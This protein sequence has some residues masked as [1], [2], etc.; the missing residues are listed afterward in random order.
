M[1]QS[2]IE[3]LQAN[4]VLVGLLVGAVTPLLTSLVQQPKWSKRTR[5]GVSAAVSVLIG[6]AIAAADGKLGSPGDVFSIIGAV[7]VAAEA[8]YQKLWKATGVAGAVENATTLKARKTGDD[9]FEA[10]LS[11]PDGYDDLGPDPGELE[12][13]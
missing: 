3:A 9:E 11:D 6:F 13:K 1:F 8:F 10:Y 2:L 5:I 7:L 4:V 12:H